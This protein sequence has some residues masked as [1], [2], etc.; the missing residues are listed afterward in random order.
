MSGGGEWKCHVW[1][2]FEQVDAISIRYWAENIS[3]GLEV[4]EIFPKQTELNEEKTYGNLVKLVLG[5]NKKTGRRGTLCDFW[6]YAPLTFDQS[7]GLIAR[8]VEWAKVNP[9]KVIVKE[10]TKIIHQ[11]PTVKG[12]I[13]GDIKELIKNGVKGEGTRHLSTYI[14][15][16]ELWRIGY[17]DN[18]ILKNCLLFNKNCEIPKAEYVI[19]NHVSY[20]LKH[21]EKYLAPHIIDEAWLEK[22]AY[23]D[24]DKLRGKSF[25][26]MMSSPLPD[27]N[28]WISGLVPKDSLLLIGGRAG[29]FKS[30]FV[31]SLCLS[32]ARQKPFIDFYYPMGLPKILLYD[33]ENGERVIHRRVKYLIGEDLNG[34]DNFTYVDNFNKTDMKGE[35]GFA[36]K[37]DIIILDSYRRFLLGE[38][39]ASEITDKFYADFLKPLRENGKTVIII[40]HF[41]K[42]RQDEEVDDEYLMELFR[43][44]SDIVAQVD[45]AYA[46]FKRNEEYDREKKQRKMI[47]NVNIAKNRLGL[48]FQRFGIDV[49]QDDNLM[50]TDLTWIKIQ[51][52]LTFEEQR[53]EEIKAFIG[54][55]EKERKEIL[56]R[57]KTIMPKLSI[58]TIDRTLTDMEAMGMITR[59]GQGLWRK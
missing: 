12:E 48:P 49:L 10:I 32:S 55:G 47:I 58:P 31:L 19:E 8:V 37:F 4:N 9:P 46:L 44:S 14:I 23:G 30:L 22:T 13:G 43:G 33:L 3:R 24:T 20:L 51:R 5:I 57:L 56:L 38:E 28:Y 40:H 6:N 7:I 15:T 39:N 29:S 45:T 11:R 17:S 50:K 25:I 2:F 34:L 35:L 36:K 54:E 18:E 27:V 26:D 59:V 41:R 1:T 52:Q 21:A 16:K 42:I 53:M